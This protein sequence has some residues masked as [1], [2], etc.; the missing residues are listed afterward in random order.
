MPL[1]P[2]KTA[3]TSDPKTP[4]PAALRER[5]V[6]FFEDDGKGLLGFIRGIQKN[7]FLV[8]PLRGKELLLAAPRLYPIQAAI[9][10]QMSTDA[11]KREFLEGLL[12]KGQAVAESIAV[13][14]IAELWELLGSEDQ[15]R[16]LGAEEIASLFFSDPNI[17]EQLGMLL[18]LLQD[19]TYF[20]RNRFLFCPRPE[21]IVLELVKAEQV[22]QQREVIHFA[23][24]NYLKKYNP[25]NP[26]EEQLAPDAQELLNELVLLASGA[27]QFEN[28]L[29]KDLKAFLDLAKAE[30]GVTRG[31]SPSEKA[32]YILRAA[33]LFSEFTNVSIARHGIDD[34]STDSD[35]RTAID[36]VH[37][38]NQTSRETRQLNWIVTIDDSTTQDRDDAVS[39]EN[40]PDGAA[41]VGIH[42][43][44]V[45]ASVSRNS[46][47]DAFAAKRASSTYLPERTFHMFPLELSAGELSLT[48]GVPRAVV[49]LY[50][51]IDASGQLI[52]TEFA[53]EVLQIQHN[54]TYVEVD[55]K[56][57]E[58]SSPELIQIL[59]FCHHQE[60]GRVQAGALRMGKIDM[61][62]QAD[63]ER[64][65]VEVVLIDENSPAR[66]LVGEL[67]IFFNRYAAEAIARSNL[68][69][70][71]RSQPATQTNAADMER[72]AALPLG[73][74]QDFAQ[75]GTL[76]RSQQGFSPAPHSSLGLQAYAQL[77]SPIRRY[78]DLINQRQLL[79]ALG[80]ED[81][82]YSE[83]ELL[84]LMPELEEAL[85]RVN[86]ASRE[87]TRFWLLHFFKQQV[88]GKRLL[89][90][91]V[92]RN[93]GRY[94]L[95]AISD[96]PCTLVY[97]S[98]NQIEL[99]TEVSLKITNIVPEDG[100]LH[101]KVVPADERP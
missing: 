76:Q 54:L 39:I 22:R 90:G 59:E 69:A 21:E 42:I 29:T 101:L 92:V 26:S 77:S 74:A 96:P 83:Q 47:L 8:I 2:K 53:R 70:I 87:S 15:V 7:R 73:P 12:S 60:E 20:K 65:S 10:A 94:P 66:K 55:T 98:E 100:T 4:E 46:V 23:L 85:A 13:T 19:R 79:K 57:S 78:A 82:G 61:N 95:V 9:P 72:V 38:H 30:F 91:V 63:A 6:V 35:V 75:R 89:Q 99:G 64:G 81:V 17:T 50:A 45:A 33:K 28:G 80:I 48:A 25:K 31:R 27:P 71:F 52:K 86:A 5:Q 67:M 97:D 56:L 32:Y 1:L 41:R 44:D 16:E 58:K 34:S 40:L 84:D 14:G 24:I 43:A 18:F 37:A 88:R 93:E 49:S 3:Q 68:P 11:A 51:D 36:A 62:L